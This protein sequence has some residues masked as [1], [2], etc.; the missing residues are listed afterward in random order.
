ME[1]LRTLEEEDFVILAGDRNRP[2]I[3]VGRRATL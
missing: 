1:A 3:R 2:K